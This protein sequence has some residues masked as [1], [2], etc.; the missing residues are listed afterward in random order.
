MNGL[1]GK[2]A[3]MTH[4]F[5][6]AGDEIPVTVLEMGPCP[7]VQVKNNGKDGY[8]AVQIA[9]EPLEKKDKRKTPKPRRGHFE[10]AGVKPHRHLREFRIEEGAEGA[11]KVGDVVTVGIFEG[12]D[13]VSVSGVS[14]GRGFAGVV[15]RHGYSGAPMSHGSHEQ[16]RHPGSIGMH[17][18]PGRV[19]P[20]K[21]LPGHYGV[22]KVKALNL[23][24]VKAYPERNLLLVKGSTPG[25]VGGLVT[26]EKTNR[27]K[28]REPAPEPKK[29]KKK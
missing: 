20:G 19:H 29:G 12:V 25:P 26:V 6:D 13:Y 22:E 23:E 5:N 24:V 7:V 17:A 10:K 15:K 9:F 2:K 16:F 4:I 11:P 3:G 28:R 8:T 1:I 21:K 27:K 14:K 18:E